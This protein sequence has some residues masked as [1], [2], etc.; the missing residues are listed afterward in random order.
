M[1]KYNNNNNSNKK[2]IGSYKYKSDIS[3]SNIINSRKNDF[4]GAKNI[5]TLEVVEK[6]N[7]IKE[8]KDVPNISNVTISKITKTINKTD[9][10]PTL[11]RN[12]VKN[13]FDSLKLNDYNSLSNY[14]NNVRL[15]EK[16]ITKTITEVNTIDRDNLFK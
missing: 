7:K 16:K 4:S 15:N 5:S 9:N 13:R 12:T 2:S 11:S 1:S 10:I 14:N 3:E 8:K 6:S